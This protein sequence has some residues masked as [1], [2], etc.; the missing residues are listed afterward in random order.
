MFRAATIMEQTQ[1]KKTAKPY[2][3]EF[4]DRAVRLVMEHRDEYQSEFAALTAIAGKLGCSPDSL[5]VWARQVQRD[6]GDRSGQTSAEKARIKALEREN[7]ELRQVNEILRKASAY[8]AQARA[9]PPVSQMMD[10]MR[11]PL[12]HVCMRERGAKP[13]GIRGRADLQSAAVCPFLLPGRRIAR[14]FCR[15]G[16]SYDRRAIVRDPERASRRAKS[17]AAMSLRIDGAL[18]RTTASSMVR[19]RFGTSCGGRAKMSPA[20]RWNG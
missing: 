1:K 20:A 9:R 14:Q 3:P 18:G 6:G 11:C 15:E 12:A 13:R 17:D 2:S 10:F 8:F 4:R 19:A 16:T 7:R 5:R